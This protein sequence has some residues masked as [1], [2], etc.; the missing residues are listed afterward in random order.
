MVEE[1]EGIKTDQVSRLWNSP[2]FSDRS[3]RDRE[4]IRIESL[5]VSI[6][7]IPIKSTRMFFIGEKKKLYR[8]ALAVSC[9]FI[10]HSC[11]C[12]CMCILFAHR[13]QKKKKEK[14]LSEKRCLS[15]V[16]PLSCISF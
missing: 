13:D 16:F 6:F 14:T 4:Q 1:E 11:I 7:G 5:I 15:Y 8:G 3:A 12:I 10:S 2:E 9:L